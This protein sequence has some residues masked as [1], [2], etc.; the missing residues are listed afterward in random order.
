M[1]FLNKIAWMIG[2]PAAVGTMLFVLAF[3]LFGLRRTRTMAFAVAVLGALWFY[4]WCTSAL[5]ILIAFP[6][7]NDYLQL[8]DSGKVENFPA[9]DAIVDLGGAMSFD[10]NKF[11][12]VQGPSGR[13]WHSARLWKAGKAPVV[14]P[15]GQGIAD[16]DAVF[17]RDLGV[18]ESAIRVENRARN[19]EEHPKILTEML[20]ASETNK[21]KI[22]L[23]TS[24]YHM[25]RA[26]YMFEKYAP[27]IECYPCVAD[28]DV[29]CSE[30]WTWGRFLP[31]AANFEANARFFH[32]WLGLWRYRHF[33]R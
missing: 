17:I 9:A 33:R 27:H 28:V 3:A 19:T 11:N 12:Y 22:L 4:A 15:T 31:V 5:T 24:A 32:E 26:M 18:P 13:A 23:V 1:Y 10:T 29:S 2:N 14:I 21:V 7:E 20:R 6:L 8:G 25:K 16:T 30:E